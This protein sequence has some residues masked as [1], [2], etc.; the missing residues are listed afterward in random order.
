MNQEHS[1]VQ[2]ASE[3]LK[4][5]EECGDQFEV[6][7]CA[8]KEHLMPVLSPYAELWYRHILNKRVGDG[9]T[10]QPEWMPFGGSH[11]TALIRLHHAHQAKQE[12]INL[13]CHFQDVPNSALTKNDYSVLLRIHAACAAFWENLGSAIDNFFCAK[14][15]A[16]RVFDDKSVDWK[17]GEKCEKCEKSLEPQY[18][19]KSGPLSEAEHPAL[20]QAYQRRTQF[21]H[22]RLVPKTIDSGMVLF[23]ALDYQDENTKWP[24]EAVKPAMLDSVI[25][26]EWD[27]VLKAFVDEW[28]KLH[29]YLQKHDKQSSASQFTSISNVFTVLST[30]D[31]SSGLT[32]TNPISGS[33]NIQP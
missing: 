4:V 28:W 14:F 13:C 9:S 23:N 15:E 8:E 6:L 2:Q 1:H 7:I 3:A 22:S 19:T 32:Y 11:Y 24:A 31:T 33:F 12:V 18:K 29:F 30:S 20:Y 16:M 10:L 27:N 26:V 21:I 5:L 17:R 25:E